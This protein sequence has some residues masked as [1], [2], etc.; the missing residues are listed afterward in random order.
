MILVNRNFGNPVLA[1]VIG[2]M[3]RSSSDEGQNIEWVNHTNVLASGSSLVSS[4]KNILYDTGD[5]SGS[6]GVAT[7]SAT[8]AAAKIP[9]DNFNN[10]PKNIYIVTEHF[11]KVLDK[12]YTKIWNESFTENGIYVPSNLSTLFNGFSVDTGDIQESNSNIM[13]FKKFV[14]RCITAGILQEEDR[15]QYEDQVLIND[16][17]KTN[18]STQIDLESKLITFTSAEPM[19]IQPDIDARE[20]QYL[21]GKKLFL[22]MTPYQTN[23]ETIKNILPTT[24]FTGTEPFRNGSYVR[25]D[26]NPSGSGS[27]AGSIVY[28][29]LVNTPVRRPLAFF[30]PKTDA[31]KFGRSLP[32]ATHLIWS[33]GTP[34]DKE[35]AMLEGKPVPDLIF[36]HLDRIS[37]IDSLTLKIKFDK[38]SF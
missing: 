9:Y 30:K 28:N 35:L 23:E 33:I 15:L 10:S 17:N 38:L 32:L 7:A 24:V 11:L 26:A 2:D 5:L 3:F 14:D 29:Y 37:H 19:N 20:G 8:A 18:I 31:S 34:E 1:E 16:L 4:L 27:G 22:M 21:Y 36:D 13:I 25:Y 6:V 12:V